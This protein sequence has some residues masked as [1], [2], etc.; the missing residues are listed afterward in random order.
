MKRFFVCLLVLSTTQMEA[1]GGK[2]ELIGKSK[3]VVDYVSSHEEEDQLSILTHCI[4]WG[5]RMSDSFLYYVG[6][7]MC[8]N[9][10]LRHELFSHQ[11]RR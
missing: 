10:W 6:L 8:V 7:F 11:H 5:Q 1:M 9:L 4:A 3:E 2:N